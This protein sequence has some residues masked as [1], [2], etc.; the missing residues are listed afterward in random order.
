MSI[1]NKTIFKKITCTH[2]FRSDPRMNVH[3]AEN[4]FAITRLV[5]NYSKISGAFDRISSDSRLKMFRELFFQES[6]VLNI[7][8]VY[9][10]K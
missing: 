3:I 8:N 4:E 7:K 9:K 5:Q 10:Y 2:Q 6:S 1:T